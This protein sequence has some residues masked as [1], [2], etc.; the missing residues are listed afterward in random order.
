MAVPRRYLWHARKVWEVVVLLRGAV[1]R[2]GSQLAFA[3]RHG[4]NRTQ[5]LNGKKAGPAI[6]NALGLRKV[7]VAG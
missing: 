1:E 7:Y 5:V 3:R 4:V 6:T 2:E